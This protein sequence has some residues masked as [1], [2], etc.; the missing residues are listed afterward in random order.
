MSA[1]LGVISRACGHVLGIA[2]PVILLAPVAPAG[3]QAAVGRA[4]ESS[5]SKLP[6]IQKLGEDTTGYVYRMG[7][8]E[9]RGR[10]AG[11]QALAAIEDPQAKAFFDALKAV[12]QREHPSSPA[13]RF[14]LSAL[15]E[16]LVMA[17]RPAPRPD[18]KTAEEIEEGARTPEPLNFAIVT[19][20]PQS[21][22][23]FER[24]Y[25]DAVKSLSEVAKVEA[26]RSSVGPVTFDVLGRP[27]TGIHAALHDGRCYWAAGSDSARWASGLSPQAKSLDRSELFQATAGP[28]FKGQ[29]QPPVA[30]YYYDLR[31]WWQHMDALDPQSGWKQVS[32]RS[33]DGVAG[34]TFVEKDHYR[35][36]HYWRVGPD[37]YGLFQHSRDARV[38][39]AWLKRV[40]ADSSG[41]TTGVYDACSLFAFLPTIFMQLFGSE[42]RTIAQAPTFVMPFQPILEQLGPRYLIYRVPGRYGSFPLA[43]PFP[44]SN[45]VVISEL[46]DAAAF[47]QALDAFNMGPLQSQT[48]TVL[49]RKVISLNL[50][51]FTI[52]VAVLEKE[53]LISLHPQLLKDAIEAA[54]R[55]G[56][57]IID[58][59]AFKEARRD[60]PTDACFLLYLPP[61]GF[62]RGIYDHYVPMLQQML[63]MASMLPAGGPP[64]EEA[65][66]LDPIVFPR[67]SDIARHARQATFLTAV[68]DGRGVLFDGTAPILATPYY[69]A[70]IH[71]LTRLK[72]LDSQTPALMLIAFPFMGAPGN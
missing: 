19:P 23:G 40:P 9:L 49:G 14:I 68:D 64:A 60:F 20:G 55:P 62:S 13:Y 24:L 22:A 47:E 17:T 32:W 46:K 54:G 1:P 59:P 36:R 44:L 69:W 29:N 43:D 33:L 31:P 42:D 15:H 18:A 65:H 11:T 34:A 6:D 61:G 27:R 52:Y 5:L 39:E 70:Y 37:R 72:P 10:L 38:N 71:A 21:R 51:Y 4:A 30:L 45:A 16:Q 63:A 28:L 56:S 57:S 53:A 25:A 41:F 26:T 3:D 66:G 35:N 67:G 8:E 12:G 48:T 50:M 58:T 2:L 7:W